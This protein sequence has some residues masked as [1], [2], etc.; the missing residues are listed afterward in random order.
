MVK[1]EFF[2]AGLAYA[3][4]KK[5][6]IYFTQK[7]VSRFEFKKETVSKLETASFLKIIRLPEALFPVLPD[8][9][10]KMPTA[11]KMPV[12]VRS[13]HQPVSSVDFLKRQG[14]TYPELLTLPD[15]QDILY[16]AVK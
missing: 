16:F 9:V 6:V 11:G 2:R 5:F 10:S 4:S 3:M 12:S 13:D 15:F 7:N 8:V 1:G 14:C